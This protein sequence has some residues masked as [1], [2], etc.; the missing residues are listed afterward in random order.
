MSIKQQFTSGQAKEIGNKLGI[1]WNKI[2]L[3]QFRHGMDI[4]LEHGNVN[5]K[6]NLTNND[7]YKTGQIAL[8]HLNEYP[9]YYDR[10]DKLEIEAEVSDENKTPN[11]SE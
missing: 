10:L 3:E 7:P 11:D 5:D 9:D 4:E 2:D 6:T 1:D 8:A